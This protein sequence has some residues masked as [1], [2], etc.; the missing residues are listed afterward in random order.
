M[1][2]LQGQSVLLS[3]LKDVVAGCRSARRYSHPTLAP[4]RLPWPT[5]LVSPFPV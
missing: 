1:L 5:S 3:A 2:C 4:P